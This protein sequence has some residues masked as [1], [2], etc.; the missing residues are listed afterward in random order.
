MDDI[1]GLTFVGGEDG[2]SK[3]KWDSFKEDINGFGIL[4]WTVEDPS[5]SADFLDLTLPFKDEKTI[6]KTYQ[7]PL[8]IY[9]YIC[10]NSAHTP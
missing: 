10:P 8:N 1:Y 6:F 9:Q 3:E 4:K 2:Y 7:K 5:L